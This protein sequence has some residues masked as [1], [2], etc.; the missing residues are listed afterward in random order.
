MHDLDEGLPL[1]HLTARWLLE[2]CW[3]RKNYEAVNS[4]LH[5][6]LHLH[7]ATIAGIDANTEKWEG[8]GAGEGEKERWERRKGTG[9]ADI[10]VGVQ[11][12]DRVLDKIAAG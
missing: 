3:L 12:H 10:V 6:F 7:A 2:A 5:R 9:E 11:T 1:L 8:G 4:Y